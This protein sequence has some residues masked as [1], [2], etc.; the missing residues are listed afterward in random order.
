MGFAARATLNFAN[1]VFNAG[2]F[3]LVKR[4]NVTPNIAAEVDDMAMVRLLARKGVGL[5]I[6][7]EVVAADELRTG[8]LRTAPFDLRITEIFFAV[9]L[10]RQVPR[11]AVAE[12]L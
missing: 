3:S 2:W 5:A 11:P 10:A 6:A 12:L 1:Q 8:R 4:V 7:P 9:T